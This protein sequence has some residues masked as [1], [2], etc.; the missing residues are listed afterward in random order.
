MRTTYRSLAVLLAI[1]VV[2]F[3]VAAFAAQFRP[4]AWYAALAK[5]PGTP[6][7]AVFAPVWTLLYALMALAAWQVWHRRGRVKA[8]MIAY[9]VQ[10]A[11][12]GVWS[13][14]FFGQH[15]IGL[16]ALEIVVLWL[17][18]LAT[19]VIFWRQSRCAALLLLPYGAWVAFA[20]Y[21][22]VALW[23]LNG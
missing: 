8:A 16:A 19:V 4:G 22:N 20:V 6:P 18:V 14:L 17:C 10:L 3:G 5:P 21:L 23:R 15:R 12:N 9:A 13:W 1:A 2:T 11:L 7:D